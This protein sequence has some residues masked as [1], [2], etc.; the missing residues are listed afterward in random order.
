[1]TFICYSYVRSLLWKI[2][3]TVSVLGTNVLMFVH[4]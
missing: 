1:M 2:Y 4:G 3:Y